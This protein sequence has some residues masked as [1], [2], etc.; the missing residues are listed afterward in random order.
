MAGSIALLCVALSFLPLSGQT[1]S[2]GNAASGA[3]QVAPGSLLRI[4]WYAPNGVGTPA[5]PTT[6]VGLQ[7]QGTR[8]AFSAQIINSAL[9]NEVLAVVPNEIP[10]GPTDVLLILNGVRFPHAPVIV[11]PAAIGIFTVFGSATGPARAQNISSDATPQLNQLTNPVLPGQYVTLW[12]TGLGAF[13]MPDI[14]I[15]L[16][17]EAVQPI[18][19]GPAPELP[20]VDQINFLVPLDAA[21]GCYVPV[22]ISAGNFTSNTVAL[23]VATSSGV[24][25]HPLGLTAGQEMALDQGSGVLVGSMGFGGSIAPSATNLAAYT[26]VE[27]FTAQFQLRYA[28]D[29]FE[30]SPAFGVDSVAPSSC[31]IFKLMPALIGEIPI[32]T[33]PA[34]PSLSLTGPSNQAVEVQANPF[35]YSFS[36]P[37]PPTVATVAQLPPPFFVP[38]SWQVTAPGGD[39]VGAF[40]QVYTLPPQ[41]RWTNRESLTTVTREKD[42]PITWNPLGYSA[43]DVISISLYG[44]SAG[45]ACTAPAQQGSL[46]LPTSL[47]GQIGPGSGSLGL[48]I[49]PQRSTVFS[50]RLTVG[51]T[52]PGI[53]SYAFSDGLAVTIQ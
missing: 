4:F 2:V 23:S 44:A 11:V 45:V 34:G 52:A 21:V 14:T 17:G 24:C 26:R 25:V 1:I 37:Q 41:V 18:F 19:A 33:A 32:G 36:A 49:R 39:T 13:T 28:L 50:L 48:F 35:G 53:L 43:Q 15:S 30:L 5:P 27:S 47:L 12:A 29:V 6:S 31:G 51:G 22:V 9:S 40:Q 38:G 10:L 20:G 3:S 8:R 42:L 7:P 46:A 16:A